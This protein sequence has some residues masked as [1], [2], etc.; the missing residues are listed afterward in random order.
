MLPTRTLPSVVHTPRLV[1]QRQRPEH[2]PLIKD[3]VDT[4][5]A[6]LRASVAWAQSAPTTLPALSARLAGSAAAFDAGEAWAF[7]IL[8]T[9]ETR[10]LGGAGLEP[11]EPALAALVGPDAVEAGYWLRTDATGYGYATEATAALAQLAFTQLGARRVVVC[12]DPANVASD[13]VP[14]RLG[15]RYFGIVPEAVLPARQAADGS[16]RPATTVWV[17]DAPEATA[18]GYTPQLNS[19]ALGSREPGMKVL[20][21]PSLEL[22]NRLVGTWAT[23]ATHPSVPDVVV[24]GS[25]VIQWLEGERFLMQRSR[26][27]HPD[28]PDSLSIIGF[29]ERDRADSVTEADRAAA[30]GPPL[31]M[32][33][34]D[35][36]GVFRVYE[37]S[38]DPAS[39]RLWR[40]APG[41]SQRFTGI[42]ADGGDTIVGRWQLCRDE[43]H[44]ADDLEIT[45]RRRE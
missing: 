9:T 10:V 23:E 44:W 11:A 24:H 40:D 1:L 21:D 25:A 37:V 19:G 17:L 15:F 20:L 32:H 38:I 35:S 16:V 3:A 13:G 39:W 4:S 45:Y 42:V 14:R 5:L 6:H 22:L 31:R 36:R 30:G 8:D 33:Y 29:M 43:L 34:F 2:A 28:F 41:F 12:H 27:D 18:A 26:T 7:T